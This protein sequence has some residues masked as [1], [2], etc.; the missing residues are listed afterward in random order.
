MI[1]LL[2]ASGLIAGLPQSSVVTLCNT[3]YYRQTYKHER[4]SWQRA[5]VYLDWVGVEL[6]PQDKWE[7]KTFCA[8]QPRNDES[9]TPDLPESQGGS[10][11]SVGDNKGGSK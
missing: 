8:W 7:I 10:D 6:R 11:A 5:W 1:G 3:V 9:H 2:L 4:D